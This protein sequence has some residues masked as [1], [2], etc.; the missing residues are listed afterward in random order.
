ME[1]VEGLSDERLLIRSTIKAQTG[2]VPAALENLGQQKSPD[3]IIVETDAQGD[4]LFDELEELAN[5]CDPGVRLLLIGSQNDIL[6]FRDLMKMGVSEYLLAP[7]TTAQLLE[8]TVEAFRDDDKDRNGRMLAVLGARGG[9]GS[10]DIAHNLAVELQKDYGGEVI[11][12][13]LDLFFGTAALAFNVQPQQTV[14]DALT[15]HSRLDAALLN[16]FLVKVDDHISLLASPANLNNNFNMTPEA[17]DALLTLVRQMADFIVIDLP[18]QWDGWVQDVLVNADEVIL[19]TQPDLASLRDTKNI[20]EALSSKRGRNAPAKM[21]FNQMG[22]TKKTE[23]SE[24]NFK[25][26]LNVSP[27]A[28]VPYEPALFGTALNNGDIVVNMKGNSKIASA[29]KG[30]AGLVSGREAVANEKRGVFSFIKK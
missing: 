16:R 21:V 20:L 30:L 1:A 26:T 29:M 6:L 24:S 3:L 14:L 19:V 7:V 12:V 27:S 5:V 2:G 15:Q 11:L 9:A 13:D 28:T 23:L 4:A 17:V 25:K 18:H 8:S 10:S 22:R